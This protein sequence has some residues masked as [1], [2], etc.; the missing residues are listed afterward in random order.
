MATLT[1]DDFARLQ[2]RA[3]DGT[4]TVSDARRLLSEALLERGARKAVEEDLARER[5]YHSDLADILDSQRKRYAELQGQMDV[6]Q[7]KI[8]GVREELKQLT[9]R[10]GVD[11]TTAHQITL[12]LY[13]LR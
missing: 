3:R 13:H 6:L 1:D 9:Q 12:A 2:Q 4:L 7:E 10:E 8:V 5:F 11:A